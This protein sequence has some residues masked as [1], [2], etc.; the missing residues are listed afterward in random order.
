MAVNGTTL[1]FDFNGKSGVA[2]CITLRHAG[3]AAFVRD[4]MAIPG[5]ELFQYLDESGHR[6]RV[7]AAD[8]NGFLQ[9]ITGANFTAKDFRTW[10]ASV[11]ALAELR[12]R[13]A[14]SAAQARRQAIETIKAVAEK[15]GNTPAVCRKSYIHPGL[16]ERYKACTLDAGDAGSTATESGRVMKMRGPGVTN[17]GLRRGM[18]NRGLRRG[19][20]IRG[21][22]RDESEF[23]ACLNAW[24]TTN[25]DSPPAARVVS[26]DERKRTA[27]DGSW[28]AHKHP[29]RQRIAA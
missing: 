2:H 13:T 9:D 20:T 11:L 23:L 12:K 6:H 8:V 21:L 24:Q 15:L 10:G 28:P 1:H 7:T 14:E 27:V 29:G 22:R 25:G 3:L 19:V 26:L 17:R 5:R 16:I 4:C 18:T